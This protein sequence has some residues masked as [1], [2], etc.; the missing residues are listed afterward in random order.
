M[1]GWFRRRRPAPAPPRIAI[2]DI[3]VIAHCGLTLD[4]WDAMSSLAKVDKR[5]GY[6]Q[7]QGLG[8]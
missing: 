1:R 2:E 3:R 4:E 8:A 6:Y 7:A 5:E